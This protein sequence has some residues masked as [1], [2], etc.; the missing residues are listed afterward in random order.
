LILAAYLIIAALYAHYTPPW[1]VPDEPAHYNYVAQI[2]ADGCCPVI[3]PGDYDQGYLNELT[4]SGFPDDAD[5]S[6]I[7]Y[8]DHQPPLYYL[9]ATPIFVLSGGSL[10][11]LRL[12]SVALSAVTIILIY[13]V[14]IRV[15]PDRPEIALASAAFVAFVPQHVAMMA[16]VNNDSL[17]ELVLGLNLLALVTYLGN[18]SPADGE[19]RQGVHPALLG[20]LVGLA[21]LTKATVTLITPPLVALAIFLRRRREEQSWGWFA[22]QAAWAGGIALAIGALWWVRDVTVYGWPD[23]FGLATHD[24]VATAGGQLRTA[25]LIAEIG[26]GEYLPLFFTTTFHSFW[27]QFGWMGVPMPPRT[28]LIIG[29][30]VVWDIVGYCGLLIAFRK[31]LNLVNAARDGGWLLVALAGLTALAYVGYNLSFVQF[32]GRYLFPALP[33]LGLGA[34][35][36]V[37]G[38]TLILR[39]RWPLLRWMPLAMMG[40]L[41]LLDVWALFRYIVPNLS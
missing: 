8:E 1:Q 27:G 28:Y 33:A 3:A 4:G 40:L 14:A 36:G 39:E 31:R 11:A 21:F 16:G 20:L 13:L 38:W 25:D 24:Q 18:S 5:L 29:L 41:A 6:P 10:T 2:V 19:A 7:E 34:A 9:L 37:L 23:L 12:F 35:L 17:A 26:W 30:F 22:R 32:Q 15:L